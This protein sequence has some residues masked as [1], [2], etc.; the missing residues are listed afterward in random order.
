MIDVLE[1]VVPDRKEGVYR[2]VFVNGYSLTI[3]EDAFMFHCRL[4]F[5]NECI[6]FEYSQKPILSSLIVYSLFETYG[7]PL[8]FSVD[9]MSRIGVPVDEEGFHQLEELQHKR[10]KDTYKDKN[11]FG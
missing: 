4:L 11:A 2:F 10:N 7:L 5:E 6:F 9:E 3:Q 1:Q 8:E